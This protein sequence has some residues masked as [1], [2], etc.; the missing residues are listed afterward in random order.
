MYLTLEEVKEELDK[1]LRNG[2]NV[3]ESVCVLSTFNKQGQAGNK[4]SMEII[5]SPVFSKQ[6][7]DDISRK[8][9]LRPAQKEEEKIPPVG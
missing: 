1:I 8:V 5:Y 2:K 3:M 4:L 7:A 6:D 9:M